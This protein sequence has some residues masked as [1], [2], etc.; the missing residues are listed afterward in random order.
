MLVRTTDNRDR[1]AHLAKD[2]E[3]TLCGKSADP[4]K[5]VKGLEI[6]DKCLD[7]ARTKTK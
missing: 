1:C 3:H 2:D 4:T 6:C 7:S 5:S